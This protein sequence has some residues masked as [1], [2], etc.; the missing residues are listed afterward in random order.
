MPN[1]VIT[2]D[3]SF[4]RILA[5]GN[6][7][8]PTAVKSIKLKKGTIIQNGEIIKDSKGRPL[9]LFVKPDI[10]IPLVYLK[11]VITRDINGV[12]ID[13]KKSNFESSQPAPTTTKIGILSNKKT[14]YIDGAI[15][16]GLLGLGIG[17]LAEKKEWLG[18]NN[19]PNNKWYSAG[20]GALAGIYFVYR[21]N[22]KE[23]IKTQK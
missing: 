11:E 2:K 21:L 13:N 5:T 8:T 16:G 6:P 15:L 7:N 19:N 4:P 18:E 20:I 22:T 3:C 10:M 23:V 14:K 17:Y 12:N 1:Y 9:Q